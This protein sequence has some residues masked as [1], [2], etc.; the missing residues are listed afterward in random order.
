MRTFLSILL[1][2]LIIINLSVIAVLTNDQNVKVIVYGFGLC[3]S[4]RDFMKF[5][6]EHGI[7]YK[8]R[9]LVNKDYSLQF[10]SLRSNLSKLL[11]ISK[12][13]IV[14]P[15]T[16]IYDDSGYPVCIIVGDVKDID[17]INMVLNSKYNGSI[18]VKLSSSVETIKYREFIEYLRSLY[19]GEN[20]DYTSNRV[21]DP[22][23]FT[24]LMLGLAV[25]D[26]INP[27]AISTTALLAITATTVG[28]MGRRKY[29]LVASFIA[30]VYLG[31]L[32]LG[33]IVS[34]I[35]SLYN[36]LLVI[37][38]ALALAIVVKDLV[39]L[40]RGGYRGIECTGR[41]CLPSFISKLP[42]HLLPLALI[43][44]GM[45]V[46]WTFMSCSA[47]PYFI[48]LSYVSVYVD[49]VFMRLIYLIIYCLVIIAPLVIV[50]LIP[51]E[52]VV[53]FRSIGRIILIRDTLLSIIVAY[54][55]YNILLTLGIL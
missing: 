2:L 26:S 36:L 21:F 35:L 53:G 46:S 19:H 6:D 39:E 10:E 17:F 43:G 55:L 45:I 48:F 50:S 47:A 44:F 7:S 34:I 42:L 41:E 27:C 20:I 3:G 8:H 51:I 16:I 31:Y 22:I 12:E 24:G 33:Y 30:G 18:I 9:D 5:L 52:K 38:L 25:A 32:L 28:F 15:L 23:S 14:E 37:V 13:S 49:N 40:A 1:V 4:C 29:L 11:N 54:T